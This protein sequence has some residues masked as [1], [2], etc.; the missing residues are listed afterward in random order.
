[1]PKDQDNPAIDYLTFGSR[2]G[3]ILSAC[4][5]NGICMVHFCGPEDISAAK[6]VDQLNHF[7]GHHSI[8]RSSDSPL[9]RQ[10]RETV[11]AYL[12]YRAP[13]PR[14]PLDLSRGTLFQQ[15][16]W[17]AL[18][19]IPFGETRSY[20]EVAESIGRPRAARAVGQACGKNPIAIVVP[21]HRVITGK[22]AL[23][24][25]SNGVEIKEALLLMEKQQL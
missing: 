14:F 5:A 16:V 11:G 12:S 15:E 7:Q 6:A 4:T 22:G 25:Y 3:W 18:V 24:G 10:V 1:M 2:F 17:R 20:R 8:R 21:C 23:G 13:L 19:D 9:L